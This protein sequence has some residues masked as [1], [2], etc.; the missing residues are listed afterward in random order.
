MFYIFYVMVELSTGTSG[1]GEKS[2]NIPKM[3]TYDP[4]TSAIKEI[5]LIIVFFIST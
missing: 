5:I 1:L 2:S 4:D 3:D